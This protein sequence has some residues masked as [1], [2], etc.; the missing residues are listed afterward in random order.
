MP[1]DDPT[2]LTRDPV[3]QLNSCLWLVRRSPTERIVPDRP[4]LA[5]KGYDL[6]ALSLTIASPPALREIF[7][8]QSW[9]AFA[10]EPDVVLL[11]SARSEHLVMEC[12]AQSFGIDSSN[13]GQARKLLAFCSDSNASLGSPG[14][15]PVVYV[16]PTEDVPGQLETLGELAAVLD[17]AG[18]GCAPYGA[19]GLR[20]DESGLWGDLV[21]DFLPAESA[22]EE[23]CGSFQIKEA[24]DGDVRPIYLIPFDPA[25]ADNQND[26]ERQYCAK[27][28]AER[29]SNEALSLIGNAEFPVDVELDSAELLAAATFQVS[30]KWDAAELRK[31]NAKIANYIARQLRRS[32][33]LKAKIKHRRSS[34]SLTIDDDAD[35]RAA[36]DIFMQRNEPG[37][38]SE[39]LLDSQLDAAGEPDF[40]F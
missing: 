14:L 37:K 32:P 9:S 20:I 12:K 35:Q 19:L 7:A 26:D 29:V 18:C 36:I 17:S 30:R 24:D 10:P 13:V 34:V 22:I 33:Q 11:H 16:V 2:L 27:L 3:F 4:A 1:A 40:D 28:L 21:V 38:L 6:R 15:A 5:A 8:A 25:A 31:F 23:A 39:G